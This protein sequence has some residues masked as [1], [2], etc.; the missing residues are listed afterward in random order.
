MKAL[1]L[2][3][4]STLIAGTCLAQPPAERAPEAPP[5]F[6]KLDLTVRELEGGKIVTSRAYSQSVALGSPHNRASVRTGDKIPT[7]V[8][9]NGQF[10][11]T[12]VGVNLD[13]FL[14][15]ASATELVMQVTADIS[16]LVEKPGGGPPVINQTRWNGGVAVRLHPQ[17]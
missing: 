3:L 8:S 2:I 10:N 13:C 11:Y 6:Y 7:I 12:D 14:T 5:K 1:I 4:A 9:P 16:S 15:H 17:M